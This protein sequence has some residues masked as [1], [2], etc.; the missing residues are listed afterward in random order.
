MRKLTALTSEPKQRFSVTISGYDAVTIY[1]EYKPL[2]YGW[3]MNLT[4]GNFVLNNERISNSYNLL[5]QFQDL[6]PFGIH[7]Y[8]P[9]NIDPIFIDSWINGSEIYMLDSSDFVDVEAL[10]AR[11]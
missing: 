1:I 7:V 5:R 4:W 11:V 2:Q 8:S 10:Y 9:D 6:L 3:F